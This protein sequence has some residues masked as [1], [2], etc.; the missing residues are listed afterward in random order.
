MS[1]YQVNNHSVLKVT[2]EEAQQGKSWHDIARGRANKQHGEGEEI[3]EGDI[4]AIPKHYQHP[5]L[6]QED[7]EV[8]NATLTSLEDRIKQMQSKEQQS[9]IPPTPPPPPAQQ[10]TKIDD[11]AFDDWF[12]E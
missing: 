8:V 7:P 1:K 11:D 10:P 9:R 4:H 3:P 6:A 5:G 12:K 2:K